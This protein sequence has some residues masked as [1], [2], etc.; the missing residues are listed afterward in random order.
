MLTISSSFRSSIYTNQLHTLRLTSRLSMAYIKIDQL[1][2]FFFVVGTLIGLLFQQQFPNFVR[3]V[4]EVF[5]FDTISQ[6]PI[7]F[8]FC[9]ASP[10]GASRTSIISVGSPH[11]SS[12]HFSPFISVSGS[13]VNFRGPQPSPIFYVHVI[14]CSWSALFSAAF[15]RAL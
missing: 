14:V 11:C 6:Q 9:T 4:R 13:I 10:G 2:V 8:F 3:F 12:D 1:I 15:Y 7:G 5:S